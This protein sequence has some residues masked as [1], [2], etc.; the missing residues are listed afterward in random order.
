[1]TIDIVSQVSAMSVSFITVGLKGFQHKN[2]IGGHLKMVVVTSYCHAVCDVV[3]V[4]LVVK[5]GLDVAIAV[6]TGA[7]LGML[8][9]I[10]LHDRFLNPKK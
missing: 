3:L 7:A 10:L 8:V 1:M 4:G 5:S 2:V 6:G 9:S